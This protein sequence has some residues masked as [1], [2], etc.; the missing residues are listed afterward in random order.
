MPR[1]LFLLLALIPLAWNQTLTIRTLA[2]SNSVA[3]AALAQNAALAST[4][5]IAVDPAGNVFV[6]DGPDHR[7]RRIDPSGRVTTVAGNGQPGFSGDGGPAASAQLNSP[8]GLAIDATGNLYI[9]D[10]GNARIRRVSAAGVITTVAGGGATNVSLFGA[11]AKATDAL[12]NAPR[13]L[14]IDATG[15]VYLSDFGANRVYRLSPDGQIFHVAGAADAGNAAENATALTA[16]LKSPTALAFD[17]AGLLYIADSGNSAIRRL[18]RGQ[19]ARVTSTGGFNPDLRFAT[20]TGLAVDAASGDLYVAEGRDSPVRRISA[21]GAFVFPNGARDVAIDATGTVWLA[22]GPFVR[23]FSR[24][25]SEIVAGTGSFQFGGDGGPATE[26]RLR[27]PAAVAAGRDGF[28]FIA[29]T[30]NHRIRRVSPDGRID[31]VAGTGEAGFGGDANLA[32][33]AKLRSPMGVAIDPDGNLWIADTGNHAVRRVNRAGIIDTIAGTGEAGSAGDNGTARRAQLNL[34][35]ALAFDNAGLLT[36]ADTGNHR[37]AR[38][39]AAGVFSVIAGRGT[40][41]NTGDG[42]LARTAALSRPTSLGYDSRGLLFLVDSGNRRIRWVNAQGLM[43]GFPSEGLIEPVALAWAGDSFYLSDP[44]RQRIFLVAANGARANAAGNGDPGFS[45]DDGP[46][47][48]AALNRPMGLAVSATGEL[49][50]ADQEN[51]RIRVASRPTTAPAAVTQPALTAIV[52]AATLRPSPVVPGSLFTLFGNGLGPAAGTLGRVDLL[53]RWETS[54]VGVEVRFDSLPA[55][56]FYVSDTQINLQVPRGIVGRARVTV[57]VL[58]NGSVRANRTVDVMDAAPALFTGDN[59]QVAALNEDGGAN[60]TVNPA[61][62]GS[63]VTFFA[64]GSGLWD[65]DLPDGVPAMLPLPLPRLPVTLWIGGQVAEL[66]YAGA[67][68]GQVGLLQ[69]NARIPR[70]VTPGQA[71]VVLQVGDTMSE[72]GPIVSIY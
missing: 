68:P 4:E 2:G 33:A 53:G 5:G 15:Q 72:L 47:A 6:S 55:P 43:M 34:P 50:I 49:L 29:D 42:A 20:I 36:I 8:Y 64:T 11:P 67:A 40:P 62:R 28:V 21:S 13:N 46:A 61:A 71:A 25:G 54:A 44:G 26:A 16:P 10:L 24:L 19:L 63:V 66:Q 65:V 3:E 30:A 1:Y 39:S 22:D 7:V 37:I 38:V 31:T 69:I 32:I 51:H 17:R 12:L 9:A 48:A 14:A 23:K 57:T 35:Q 59:R 70:G 18:Q 27:S 58:L 60:L 56:L 41:G 52:H 45:G